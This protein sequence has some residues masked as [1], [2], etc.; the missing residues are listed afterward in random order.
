MSMAP[1]VPQQG[2]DGHLMLREVWQ[3]LAPRRPSPILVE[4]NIV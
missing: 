3:V 2:E 1:L 4:L